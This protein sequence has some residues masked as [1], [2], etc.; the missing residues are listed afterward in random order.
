MDR[1]KMRSILPRSFLKP[2]RVR[3]ELVNERGY[4]LF[5]SKFDDRNRS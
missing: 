1:C 5:P 3:E 4:R 2:G